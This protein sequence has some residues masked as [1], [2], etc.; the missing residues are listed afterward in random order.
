LA[1]RLRRV[2]ADL[3]SPLVLGYTSEIFLY[4]RRD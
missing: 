1:E 3:A 2:A 4:E